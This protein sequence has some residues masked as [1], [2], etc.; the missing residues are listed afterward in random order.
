MEIPAVGTLDQSFR[1]QLSFPSGT[2]R[3]RANYEI[4]PNPTRPDRRPSVH[5]K[6]SEE[7]HS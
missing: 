7:L 2:I 3:R 6:R 5:P 1:L 4:M